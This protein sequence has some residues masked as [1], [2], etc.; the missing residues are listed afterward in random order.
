[1]GK[2]SPS[3]ESDEAITPLELFKKFKR[4][5]PLEPSLG[6]LGFFLV[7]VIFISS[8]FYLDYE[9]V[10]NGLRSGGTWLG[11]H[12]S[13]SLSSSTSSSSSFSSSSS[14]SCGNERLG[15][16]DEGGDKC[17]VFDGSWVW[18]ESYP[19]YESRNC[20]F[21]D[22]GF[23]CSENGRPDAFYT[24]WRWQPKDCNLPRFDGAK[25]LESLRNKRL[26]FAGDSL[27]RNQWESLLCMLSAVVSN[28]SSIYEMNGNPITK[29]SGSLVFKFED[30]NCTVEYYRSPFLVVQGHPPAGA[31]EEVKF[32]MR[33]DEMDWSSVHWK[34]ADVLVL[35]TGHWWIYERTIR[36]GCYFQEEGKVKKNMSLESGYRRSIET[37]IDWIGNQV[38]LNKTTIFFRT[39]SP[40]HFRGGE[41]NT[42]GGCHLETLPDFNPVPVLSEPHFST[43]AEVLAERS[44]ESHVMQL[45]VLNVTDMTL[46][47]KDGHPS[48]YY[49]GPENGLASLHHQDCSHWC[50]PGVPDS[51][52]ELLYAI[53]L[54]RESIRA[55][56]AMGSSESP[57]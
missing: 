55:G 41:W 8:F 17:D 9:A 29:H 13:S 10:A 20:S 32:T 36:E 46:R 7:T 33:V 48:I 24:K 56:N 50:L 31:S 11:L 19:L 30:F 57:S 43:A 28:K 52:N 34:D 42:G 16:L 4:F 25:M 39:Y 6:L 38:N 18:D 45:V 3:E 1:M 22:F 26:V 54:K 2:S 23:A 40:V 44:N 51:W 5:N 14:S 12:G 47:R 27:G 21:V 15:F 53:F 35:N 49:L 37:V